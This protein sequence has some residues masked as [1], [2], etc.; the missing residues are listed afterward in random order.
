MLG[1]RK[2]MGLDVNEHSIAVVE[3]HASAGR[4]ELTRVAEFLLP[5]DMSWDQPENLGHAFRTFLSEKQFSARRAFVGLPAKW[6]LVKEE[7]VPPVGGETLAGVL[8]IRAER[9]FSGN[10]EDLAIDYID[11]PM[12]GERR[13]VLLVGTLR[14]K[15]EQVLAMM[16]AAGLKAQAIMSTV[17]AI[18]SADSY[19]RFEHGI[20][21]HLTSRGTEL[22]ALSNGR[23]SALRHIPVVAPAIRADADQ[24][25]N[26]RFVEQLANHV[27]RIAS[28]LPLGQATADTSELVV[29]DAVGLD[30]EAL[31]ELGSRLGMQVTVPEDFSAFGVHKSKPA[32]DAAACRFVGAVAVAVAGT[33][34]GPPAVDFLHSRLAGRKKTPIGRRV[35]WATALVGALIIACLALLADWKAKAK[36]AAELRAGLDEMAEDI[37]AARD[38]VQKVSS[39]RGWYDHRPRLLD[40][41][42]ELT[43][44]FPE[45]GRIWTTSLHVTENMNGLLSGKSTDEILTLELLDTLEASSNFDEVKLLHISGTESGAGEASFAISF[46]FVDME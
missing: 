23:I 36:E 21:L 15:T 45:D 35:A 28:L 26:G 46:V 16:R 44:A 39:G 37:Q 2:I 11:Q 18:A 1:S 14:K 33:R 40:C 25:P 19:T 13:R 24:A 22:A 42:R 32:R 17:A 30:S 20:V 7:E 3:V 6:L 12:P 5:E 10:F 31:D 27:H 4:G 9:G 29:W 38:I 41:L 34:A 8:R 43:L